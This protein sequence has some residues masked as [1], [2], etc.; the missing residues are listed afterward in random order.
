MTSFC[1]NLRYEASED[2]ATES[3]VNKNTFLELECHD[4]VD[5]ASQTRRRCVSAPPRLC[6][7]AVGA[8]ANDS[9]KQLDR[10]NK[11]W[12]SLSSSGN[13]PGSRRSS[14][15]ESSDMSPE[16]A[17]SIA[18]N[19]DCEELALIVS[20]SSLAA[21]CTSPSPLASTNRHSSCDRKS[22]RP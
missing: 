4:D 8:N 15:L 21:N 2:T 6:S 11:F 22:F 3:W 12:K 7:E 14:I 18:D 19:D 13:F 5:A 9:D 1:D 10:L 20:P 17:P 16:A